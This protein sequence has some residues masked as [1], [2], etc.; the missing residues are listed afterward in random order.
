M[1]DSTLDWSDVLAT[2]VTAID[3]GQLAIVVPTFNA[4]A[5]L[6]I[7]LSYYQRLGV[8][9]TVFVDGKSRDRTED[10]ARDLATTVF[11]IDN[12]ANVVEGMIERLSTQAKATW[13]LRLDDDEFPTKAMLTYVA[14]I[15]HD[16]TV[17]AVGFVRKQC[18][19]SRRRT[20][21]AST[22]HHETDHRQWRLYRPAQMTWTQAVHTAGFT[23]VAAHSQAAPE[24]A[25]MVHLD[26][27]LHDY[28][29]RAAKVKRYDEHTIGKGSMW[30]SFYLYEDDPMHGPT[31][32]STVSASELSDTCVSIAKRFPQ[33]CVDEPGIAARLRSWWQ[34]RT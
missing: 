4:E 1:S 7:T 11:V 17:Y 32:F 19:V 29:S 33:N 24:S 14:H 12:N 27:S 16:E 34:R 21:K 8:P 22:I 28:A 31:R 20:L 2:L 30:R 5:F 3:N 6:D 10:I 26:W 18:A 25:F 9:V 23:P 13:V 15:I